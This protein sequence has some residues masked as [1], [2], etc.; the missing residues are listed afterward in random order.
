MAVDAVAKSVY[1]IGGAGD[2]GGGAGISSGEALQLPARRI[3]PAEQWGS[4]PDAPTARLMMAWTV[5]N[6]K[7]WI[8]GGL[9]DGIALPTVESYDP[10]TGA[11]QTQPP[12]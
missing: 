5:L 9:R 11:W 7:V 4:L 6:D 8:I 3:P 2:G 10:C 12:L 1:A